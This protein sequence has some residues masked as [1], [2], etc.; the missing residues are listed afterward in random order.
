VKASLSSSAPFDPLLVP[1]FLL[2]DQ[3]IGCENYRHWGC[4]GGVRLAWRPGWTSS[5]E[6]S[7]AWLRHSS[8]TILRKPWGY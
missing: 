7:T 1:G 4:D 6:R 2:W 8:I 5:H 3:R